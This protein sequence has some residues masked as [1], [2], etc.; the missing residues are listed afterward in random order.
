MLYVSE[1]TNLACLNKHVTWFELQLRY[2]VTSSLKSFKYHV[3]LH[4]HIRLRSDMKLIVSNIYN[5]INL[6]INI[7]DWTVITWWRVTKFNYLSH[8]CSRSDVT[9]FFSKYQITG[10]WKQDSHQKR[11]HATNHL[12]FDMFMVVIVEAHQSLILIWQ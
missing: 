10:N 12:F 3:P 8:F 6:C 9:V 5:V 4:L 1:R 2:F 11:F 7:Y